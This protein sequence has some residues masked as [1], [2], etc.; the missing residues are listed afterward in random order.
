MKEHQLN[1]EYLSGW[2]NYPVSRN[3][4]FE[5]RNPETLIDGMN[6]AS[7]IPR[8]LGRS[9]GDQATHSGG[10]VANLLPMNRVLG[11]DSKRGILEC[12]AGLSL[13]E[14]I[15]I[16]TPL[17]FFP[18]ITPGTKYVTV[19]GCIA[20][21]VHGKAHHVDG[22]FMESVLEYT[23]L[24]SDGKTLK[25]SRKSHPEI[26][27]AGFGSLGLLGI[28]LTAKIK[29][30]KIET[31]YFR[32]SSLRARNLEE[33]M[34]LFDSTDDQFDYSVAWVDPL[35]TKEQT[36]KGVISLGNIATGDELHEDLKNEPLKVF[37]RS[38]LNVPFYLPNFTL[39][40]LSVQILN[41]V[42]DYTLSSNKDFVSYEKF[43]YPLDAVQN[44]NRGY[45]R[46]GFI[47]YQFV[48]PMDGALYSVKRILRMISNSGCLPFLNVLKKF[49]DKKGGPLSFPMKGY[50]F[51]IDFPVSSKLIPFTR[52]LNRAVLDAGGRIYAGKDSVL[53]SETFH[54]M[55]P[56]AKDFLEIKSKLDPQNRLQSDLSRRLGLDLGSTTRIKP[57]KK[58]S[59]KKQ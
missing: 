35:A 5:A 17:G 18:F 48:V 41:R 6:H 33:M 13:E 20:N 47:Q 16:F 55:Y 9:Y 19:G 26:F 8:G 2:G 7:V 57:K 32:T 29:L 49:G 10:I 58:S 44:W 4:I 40:G 52:E 36:G 46:R 30:R 50:T 1:V 3:H 42:L 59:R 34:E 12:E 54:A 28:I 25:L 22:S 15:E 27:H 51:A 37:S 43:F 23:M 14:I 21:D 31:S 39:N 53:D 45:G 24:L 11:F 38:R 56:E